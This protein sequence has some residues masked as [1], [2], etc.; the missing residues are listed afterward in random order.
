MQA[1]VSA[2][3][4]RSSPPAPIPTLP[5]LDRD[6]DYYSAALGLLIRLALSETS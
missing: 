2:V 4:T 3:E 1:I 5:A 6:Q